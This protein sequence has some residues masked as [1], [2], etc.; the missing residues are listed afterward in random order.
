[1]VIDILYEDM[2]DLPPIHEEGQEINKF[3]LTHREESR[4]HVLFHAHLLF[5][6]ATGLFK[7]RQLPLVSKL[8]VV[9]ARYGGRCK[10]SEPLRGGTTLLE[11]AQRMEQPLRSRAAGMGMSRKRCSM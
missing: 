7:P 8:P 9:L 2:S 4:E 5:L 10:S 1:M 11:R 3:A 6:P